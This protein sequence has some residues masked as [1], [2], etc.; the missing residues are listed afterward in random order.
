MKTSANVLFL[1]FGGDLQ[2]NR[3]RS[4]N[5]LLP[6]LHQSR[7]YLHSARPLQVEGMILKVKVKYEM[8]SL[9]EF[10]FL[11]FGEEVRVSLR[12]VLV[13]LP[14]VHQSRN[15]LHSARSLH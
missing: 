2:Q 8:K 1:S 10:S 14:F 11:S 9:G 13:P 7:N 3:H 15:L 4:R 12:A 6:F 5:Y